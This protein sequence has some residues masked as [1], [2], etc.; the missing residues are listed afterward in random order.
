MREY[1]EIQKNDLVL[2]AV[3]CN[4]CGKKCSPETDVMDWQEWLHIHFVGGYDSIFGDGDEYEADFCQQCTKKLFGK[5]LTY[6][7]NRI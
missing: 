5:Y 7:G 6:L 1:K 3:S 2:D 4:K